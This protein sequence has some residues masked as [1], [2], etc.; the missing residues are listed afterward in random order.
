[1]A[2]ALNGP[3]KLALVLS[4]S[5]C[6]PSRSNLAAI[7]Q[8]FLECP[9]IFIVDVINTLFAE[10]ACSSSPS[11]PLAHTSSYSNL[12]QA[13]PKAAPRLEHYSSPTSA[14]AASG[15]V[16]PFNKI[17][18]LATSSARKR[19]FPFSVFQLRVC[20]RPST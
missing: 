2:G 3:S 7:G 1:M 10:I 8:E 5:R 12:D 6:L 11:I 18:S 13:Q 20:S 15:F 19:V 17:I 16:E 4:A 9:D 14:E